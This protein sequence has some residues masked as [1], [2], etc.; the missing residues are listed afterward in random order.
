[1]SATGN[2]L[3]PAQRVL[4]NWL[5]NLIEVESRMGH[6][7]TATWVHRSVYELVATHGSWC[8][9]AALPPRIG[10]L[11]AR[12]CF[13]NAAA[14][15]RAHPRLVYTEGFAVDDSPVPTIHA[16]CTDTEG[17]VVDPTWPDPQDGAYLGIAL[18]PALRPRAPYYRGVLVA[19]ASLYPL[20]RKGL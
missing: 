18:P 1:M 14:I 12:G 13:A 17:R 7:G 8:K 6:H 4:Q 10:Q 5:D 11:P 16:W 19:P 2:R 20:L 3:A 15:E 9:P